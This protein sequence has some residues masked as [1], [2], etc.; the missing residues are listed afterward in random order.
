M[1]VNYNVNVLFKSY[2]RHSNVKINKY[3][4]HIRISVSSVRALRHQMTNGEEISDNLSHYFPVT[5]R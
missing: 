3:L 2:N 1:N 4:R 5:L